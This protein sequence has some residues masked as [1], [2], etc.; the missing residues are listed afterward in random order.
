MGPDLYYVWVG[1]KM[2]PFDLMQLAR[3]NMASASSQ[4]WKV[5]LILDLPEPLKM[6]L[7]QFLLPS[8]PNLLYEEVGEYLEYAESNIFLRPDMDVLL[9]LSNAAQRD[10][11]EFGPFDLFDYAANLPEIA[12]H[13]DSQVFRK[14]YNCLF[15]LGI[16]AGA[17]DIVRFI[18]LHKTGGLYLDWDVSI[19]PEAQICIWNTFSLAIEDLS[20][21]QGFYNYDFGTD[22]LLAAPI[23]NIKQFLACLLAHCSCTKALDEICHAKRQPVEDSKEPCPLLTTLVCRFLGPNFLNAIFTLYA[24]P[25]QIPCSETP[26]SQH[27]NMQLIKML[28]PRP[29]QSTWSSQDNIN[30]GRRMEFNCVSQLLQRVGRGYYSRMEFSSR[31]KEVPRTLP[32]D[33][34]PPYK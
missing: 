6:R 23:P 19:K 33:L 18:A 13:F 21:G 2:P 3:M 15:G 14:A 31:R 11:Q 1:N 30:L 10:I 16:Y 17:S 26:H 7:I 12:Q 28:N 32:P 34:L 9:K 20:L 8:V 27:L 5:H 24:E 22:L 25:W 29:E 4:G